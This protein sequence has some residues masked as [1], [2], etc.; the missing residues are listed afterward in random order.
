MAHMCTSFFDELRDRLITFLL[1]VP[2]QRLITG[3]VH[4]LFG[5]N[6]GNSHLNEACRI[7]DLIRG[8]VLGPKI[9]INN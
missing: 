7:D 2:N 5:S 9:L 8:S 3:N 1:F 6:R 4:E